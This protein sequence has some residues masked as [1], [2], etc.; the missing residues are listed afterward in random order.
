MYPSTRDLRGEVL[1]G[2]VGGAE[3]CRGDSDTAL[4]PGFEVRSRMVGDLEHP[5]KSSVYVR[6]FLV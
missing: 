1:W 5:T 6:V 2:P 3:S 4:H